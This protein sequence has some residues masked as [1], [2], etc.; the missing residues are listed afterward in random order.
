[1]LVLHEDVKTMFLGDE[2]H[3]GKCGWA[4]KT[5][6]YCNWSVEFLFTEALLYGEREYCGTTRSLPHYN[7]SIVLIHKSCMLCSVD[8]KH[9]P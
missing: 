3:G 4:N 8:S 5:A 9:Q 6:P 7:Y 2:G 1:M